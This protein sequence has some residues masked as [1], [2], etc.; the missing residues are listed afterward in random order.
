[1]T[2]NLKLP[3]Y[4]TNYVDSYG[5]VNCGVNSTGESLWCST[6]GGFTKLELAAL[7]IAQ[8]RLG[9]QKIEAN[10]EAHV[11]FAFRCVA[12]AKAVLEEANK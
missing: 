9:N 7:M 1:M 12:I 10:N 3:A 4:P 5:S 2:N 8:G 11:D 6:P